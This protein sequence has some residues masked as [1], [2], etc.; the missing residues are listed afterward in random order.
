[1]ANIGKLDRRV[2]IQKRILTKDEAGGLVESWVDVC[3]SWAEKVEERGKQSEI[4]DA[5]RAENQTQWRIRYKEQF[6]GLKAA[7][8]YRLS[9]KN[10]VFD[11]HHAKEEGRKSTMLLTTLTTEAIA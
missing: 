4:T 2:T 10:E 3:H 1:M 9:Y 11:I 5:D 6:Q 7:S 8:G